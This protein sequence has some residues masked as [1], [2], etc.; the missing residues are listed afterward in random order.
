MGNEKTPEIEKWGKDMAALKYWVWLAALNGIG[1]R[2]RN[3]IIEKFGGP[4]KA[5]FA[6]DDEINRLT[7]LTT[8]EKAAI[9]DKSLGRAYGIINECRENGFRILTLND[10]EYSERLKN[11]FDPPIV[12]YIKGCLPVIDEEVVVAVVGTR[13][14]TSYGVKSAERIG[15]EIA[16]GGGVVTTG[17]AKGID[18]AAA[19]GALRAGGKVIGVLGCGLDVVY[20]AENKD[21]YKEVCANGCLIS[22]YPPGTMPVGKNFPVRNRIMSGISLGAVIIE[23]PAKSGALITAARALEQG[24]D[25]F[26]LPGNVDS[27]SCAGSNALLKEGAIAVTCGMDIIDE[28]IHLYPDKIRPVSYADEDERVGRVHKK[29]AK[30]QLTEDKNGQKT[31]KKQIDNRQE[32]A[33]IELLTK[34][35]DMTDEEF[36]VLSA[37]NGENQADEIVEKAGLPAA[38]VLASLTMLEIKGYVEQK[39]GK[40]FST[41]VQVK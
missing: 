6:R 33:Y 15:Y 7:G 5:F 18:S 19:R 3:N 28:Y 23:A 12:L 9:K 26:A 2:N 41:K 4:D 25:V 10:A 22:E 11:I 13:R 27:P 20:P 16:K 32:V 35:E 24:R 34:P 21:L 39:P 8:G 38:A 37:I 1:A 17:L 31:A 36:K 14:A 40:R 30:N 29:P